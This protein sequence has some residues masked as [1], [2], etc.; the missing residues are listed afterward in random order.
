MTV[1]LPGKIYSL[2]N[3][4]GKA[5]RVWNVGIRRDDEM[6]NANL[7]ASKVTF[8]KDG[9]SRFENS[10]KKLKAAKNYPGYT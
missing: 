10:E 5:V 1:A 7:A 6:W 8:A 2:R 3:Y 9:R 4:S